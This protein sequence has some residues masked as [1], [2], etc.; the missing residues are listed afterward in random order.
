METPNEPK[1]KMS[2]GKKVFIGVVAVIILIAIVKCGRKETDSERATRMVTEE[3]NNKPI[4]IG[5]TLHS[6]YFDVII[7]R[8]YSTSQL[9]TGNEFTNKEA[10]QG[11]VFAVLEASFTNTDKESRMIT[12]GKLILIK[13]GKEYVFEKSEIVMLKGWGIM[14]ATIN[15]LN[16]LN[17]NI[18]YQIPAN[19]KGKIFYEPSR[20]DKR[21]FIGDVNLSTK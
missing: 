4:G 3:I 18:V 21:I 1:K 7:K 6:E 10:D 20:S 11:N 5:E 19:Y 12:D 8:A 16:T 17:T 15:P 13:E 14:M 9:E 2:I